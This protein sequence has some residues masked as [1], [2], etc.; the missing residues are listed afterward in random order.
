VLGD[1]LRLPNVATWWCGR[2]DAQAVVLAELDKFVVAPAFGPVLPGLLDEGAVPIRDLPPE[3]RARIA[4]AIASRGVDFVAQEAVHL[5]TMPVW[6]EGK[7]EPRPFMLRV[8]AAR[9]HD[10][11]RVL[12]GGFCQVSASVDP[13]A[14]S[15]Q[16]G[17]SVADVWV[18]SERAEPPMTL[19]P[20]ESSAI[21]TRDSDLLP[22]R[23][24]ENLYWLG[25]YLE[26]A[27]NT[28]RLTR[29]LASRLIGFDAST[30]AM[31]PFIGKIL[32]DVGALPK[33]EA[34][35]PVGTT[36]A[37]V[38]ESLKDTEAIG[39][40]C[41]LL[42]SAR[43]CAARARDHISADAWKVMSDLVGLVQRGPADFPSTQEELGHCNEILRFVSAFAGLAH[44]SMNRLSGWHFLRLGGC[45]ERAINI[46]RLARA[47]GDTA[48][49]PGG[50]EALLE[51]ADSQISFGTLYSNVPTK[52]QIVDLVLLDTHNPR[53]LAFQT[54]RIEEHTAQLPE[55][56]RRARSS[57]SRKVAI[58]LAARIN[59]LSPSEVT[60]AVLT[61][62]IGELAALSNALT[63]DFFA[64]G[65]S[66]QDF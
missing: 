2:P 27:E 8:Y 18:L 63:A 19:L 44:N 36:D 15:L 38:F 24:A 60:D 16:R 59:V 62:I 28:A 39:G 17:S 57:V 5:S 48:A 25:R 54:M 52:P 58:T 53:S 4:D 32:V 11:W 13:R 23:T 12:P 50:F 45:I 21:A 29:A 9:T 56:R 20:A 34:G 10:G 51:L 46:A 43:N 66:D 33:T 49:P 1:E 7:L 30:D 55:M 41:R 64:N 61:Q 14:V 26:R 47:F 37:T 65:E 3:R 35:E 42:T 6:K 22:T 40:V 31:I